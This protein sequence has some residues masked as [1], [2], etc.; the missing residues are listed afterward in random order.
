MTENL[1]AYL[2]KVWNEYV[3]YKNYIKTIS[4]PISELREEVAKK[5]TQ[6]TTAEEAENLIFEGFEKNILHNGD[7]INQQNRL[8]YTVEA[9]KTS[10]EIPEEINR[11]LE[12]MKFIQIFAVK[13]GES[14]VINEEALEFTKGQIRE[15]LT[16]GVQQFKNRFL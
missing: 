3:E 5:I 12:N 16:Q 9:L 11:E 14:T 1:T 2:E 4:K 15:G 10:I 13:N 8:F 7:F 6:E